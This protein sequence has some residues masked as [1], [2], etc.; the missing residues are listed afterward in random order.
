M[1]A[2]VPYSQATRRDN[3]QVLFNIHSFTPLHR[4]VIDEDSVYECDISLS[5]SLENGWG[6]VESRKTCSCLTSLM[7][8]E[9]CEHFPRQMATSADGDRLNHFEDEDNFF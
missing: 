1:F 7:Q 2:K 5:V 9:S 4:Q 3:H 8:D 6:S